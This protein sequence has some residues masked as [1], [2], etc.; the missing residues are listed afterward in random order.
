L[1][2]VRGWLDSEWPAHTAGEQGYFDLGRTIIRA[3][4]DWASTSEAW[5]S[6]GGL[7]P[8]FSQEAVFV[9]RWVARDN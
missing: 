2:I 6:D 4:A 7:T 8:D 1:S 5:G 9:N 3:D